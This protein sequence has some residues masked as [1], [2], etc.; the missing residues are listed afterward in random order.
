MPGVAVGSQALSRRSCGN[1]QPAAAHEKGRKP[2]WCR[3]FR[4]FMDLIGP[5]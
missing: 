3:G 4:P 1:G 2:C 5:A